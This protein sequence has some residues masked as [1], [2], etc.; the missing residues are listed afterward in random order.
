MQSVTDFCNVGTV[1]YR[2]Q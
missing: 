1:D 2:Y